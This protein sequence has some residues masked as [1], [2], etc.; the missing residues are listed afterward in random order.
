M[1]YYVMCKKLLGQKQFDE[2]IKNLTNQIIKK[3]SSDIFLDKYM[4]VLEYNIRLL[5]IVS[6]GN[7]L[8]LSEAEKTQKIS[9]KENKEFL[10]Y[11]T[12]AEFE[13]NN[14][15]FISKITELLK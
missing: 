12:L 9:F 2:L 8:K 5:M 1:K 11:P 13:E 10:L 7:I 15:F 4:E 6:I 3:F 14:K